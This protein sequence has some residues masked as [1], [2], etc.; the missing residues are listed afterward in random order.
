MLPRAFCSYIPHTQSH[1]ERRALIRA[2]L[3]LPLFALAAWLAYFSIRT[4]TIPYQIEYR[5]GAAQV[6]TWLLLMG[7]NPFSTEHQPLAMN[8]YGIGYSLVVAPFAD[9]WGN[10]LVV[11][12]S[13][14]LA[15]LVATFFLAARTIRV[16]MPDPMIAASGGLFIVVILA[17]RGGLGAFPSALGTFLF[18]SGMLIPFLSSFSIPSLLVSALISILAFYT[19]PYF[20]LGFAVVAAY[21]FLFVSKRKAVLYGLFFI[22]TFVLVYAWARFTLEYYFI[23]TF[24]GNLSNAN[25]SL[26]HLGNQLLRIFAEF[27]PAIIVAIALQ[28]RGG[29]K[30]PLTDRFGIDP[31]SRANLSNAELPLLGAKVDFLGF[32]AVSCGM[33]FVVVLGAHQGSYMTSAY[34]ITVPP[35]I[36]WLFQ[37]LQAKSRLE[38]ISLGILLANI[39]MLEYLLLNPAFLRQGESL[40]WN[41]LRE[42]VANSSKVVNSPAI[43][44]MMID[45]GNLPVDSGQTE[46]Y[47]YLEPYPASVLFGPDFETA[48]RHGISYRRSIRNGISKHRF[49]RLFLTEGYG[50]LVSLDEVEQYYKKV[51]SF[52]IDMPQTSQTWVIGIW[53]P[54][55]E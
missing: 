50:N 32:A 6:L 36:L 31:L 21:T 49:E 30:L 35:F 43:V 47:Y 26:A 51:E 28:K 24:I 22:A 11:H 29:K 18:L 46:Y 52:L 19:K 13:V 23:D 5:E 17:G 37:K 48:K 25:R 54:R 9:R 8:N 16:R 44:S 12:R 14:T 34:Q 4:V 15:F 10:T 33:A 42:R 45:A 20:V 38:V 7:E 41:S 1:P 40:A 55:D 2:V 3:A 39:L 27:L 53:E